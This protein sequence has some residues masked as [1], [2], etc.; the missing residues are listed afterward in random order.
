VGIAQEDL[1]FIFE[2]FYRGPIGGAVERGSGLGLAL[3]RRIVEVHAGSISVESELG[4]GSI[5]VIRLPAL[6][7]PIPEA[8]VLAESQIGGIR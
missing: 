6:G 4:K 3:T 7:Q 1:P 5:F 8:D 2:D